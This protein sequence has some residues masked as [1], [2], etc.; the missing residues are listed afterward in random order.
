MNKKVLLVE[1]WPIILCNG[2]RKA[3]VARHLSNMDYCATKI[4]IIYVVELHVV[5][6]HRLE[7]LPFLQSK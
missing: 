3:Q 5:A 4:C 1:A 6:Q 2:K 7:S